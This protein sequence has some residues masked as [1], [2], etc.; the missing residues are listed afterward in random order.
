MPLCAVCSCAHVLVGFWARACPCAHARPHPTTPPNTYTRI[1]TPTPIPCSQVEIFDYDLVGKNDFLGQV[2]FSENS[3]LRILSD[4]PKTEEPARTF[5]LHPKHAKGK[6]SIACHL[7]EYPV[8]KP[9]VYDYELTVRR[10][11]FT[12]RRGCVREGFAPR[13]C[14]FEG[15]EGKAHDCARVK[16]QC[17]L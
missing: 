1:H 16:A 7:L 14:R 11:G 13:M 2:S 6:L 3:M 15:G 9:T 5:A 10:C 17:V 12:C 8:K 4:N